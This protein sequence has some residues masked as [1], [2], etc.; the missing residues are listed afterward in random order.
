V[1]DFKH[2]RAWQRAHALAVGLHKAARHF[3]RLNAGN[4]RTQLTRAADSI[5]AAIV[6]GCGAATNPEFA[7]YLD[8]AIK[9]ANET[10]HHLLTARDRE[11]ISYDPWQKLSAEVVEIR[12]M[13][14]GY[15]KKVLENDRN[16]RK[17]DPAPE[18]QAEAE[19]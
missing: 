5:P 2:I 15:R 6:E 4:L 3:S 19:A 1:Q 11:L 10:E 18:P 14:F 13:I 9:S 7:R 16:E 8:V 17:R 12:K